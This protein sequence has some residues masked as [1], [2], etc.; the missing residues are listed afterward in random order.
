MR[1]AIEAHSTWIRRLNGVLAGERFDLS[2]AEASVD[3]RCELGR[4]I[5]STG[6]ARFGSQADYK[7]LL[8]AHLSFHQLAG[9]IITE[10]ELGHSAE[11]L[12]QL[13][14]GMRE[15][16]GRVQLGIIRLFSS[17]HG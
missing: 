6:R 5:H 4:W 12:Q 11:E 17:Y 1:K 7:M 13:L 9:Q 2:A 3:N 8:D 10:Y 16:S 14:R 15:L